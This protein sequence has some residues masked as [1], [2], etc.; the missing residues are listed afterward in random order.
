MAERDEKIGNL[1]CSVRMIAFQSFHNSPRVSPYYRLF[2]ALLIHLL[3]EGQTRRKSKKKEPGGPI[4]EKCQASVDANDRVS[5]S[6][7]IGLES[8][9][10]A[11]KTRARKKSRRNKTKVDDNGPIGSMEPRL[12]L[13][14]V[15]DNE[16]KSNSARENSADVINSRSR[17]S[18]VDKSICLVSG[19]RPDRTNEDKTMPDKSIDVGLNSRCVAVQATTSP[20]V[21]NVKIEISN[22][23]LD[24]SKLVNRSTV[25]DGSHVKSTSVQARLPSCSR[26]VATERFEV[27]CVASQ[28][29]TCPVLV[30]S[31]PVQTSPKITPRIVN[32]VRTK[33][34]QTSPRT[35]LSSQFVKSTSVQSGSS[36]A[37]DSKAVQNCSTSPTSSPKMIPV[38]SEAKVTKIQLNPY[39]KIVD[40]LEKEDLVNLD[41]REGKSDRF[42]WTMPIV[43]NEPDECQNNTKVSAKQSGI[44]EVRQA[45]ENGETTIEKVSKECK[46]SGKAIQK[47]RSRTVIELIENFQKDLDATMEMIMSPEKSYLDEG[48]KRVDTNEGSSSSRSNRS[49]DSKILDMG[50]CIPETKRV[51]ELDPSIPLTGDPEIDEEIIAYYEAKRLGCK[52]YTEENNLF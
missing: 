48:N 24:R 38:Q 51:T 15:F 21:E 3:N 6:V 41:S 27:G 49:D 52:Q 10:V 20:R 43:K 34:C 29:V 5:N 19:Q 11:S 26:S 14:R 4:S 37:T 32:A 12:K 30:H 31:T 23:D 45:D 16:E 13:D 50:D 47:E 1:F 35:F 22:R 42:E 46:R 28:T 36:L 40:F 9:R 2:S 25:T 8:G 44:L 18:S 7:D 17:A 39:S 33:V